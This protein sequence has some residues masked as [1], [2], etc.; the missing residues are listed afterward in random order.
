LVQRAAINDLFKGIPFE[1]SFCLSHLQ[2]ADDTLIF[3]P[4]NLHMVKK[5]KRILLWFAICSG[6]HINFHK[7]SLIDINVREDTYV[8][9]A[10]SVFC[11]FDSLPCSYLGMPLGSNPKRLSTWKPIIENFR[12]KLSIWRGRMLSLVGRICLIKSVMSS[13]LV[14]YMSSFLLLKGVCIILTSIQRRFLWSR[15]AKQKKICRV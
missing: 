1:D 6:L 12:R 7:S 14:Y 10:S 8:G 5:V 9:M 11:R 15:V 4:A 2:Y 3:M 13:L